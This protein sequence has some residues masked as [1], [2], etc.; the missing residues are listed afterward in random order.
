MSSQKASNSQVEKESGETPSRVSVAKSNR[1]G[2]DTSL[3]SHLYEEIRSIPTGNYVRSP[4]VE[5]VDH[6]ESFAKMNPDQLRSK[7]KSDFKGI[8][9]TKVFD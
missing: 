6:E 5:K 9:Q 4:L 8:F 1:P 7:I 3:H 2:Y